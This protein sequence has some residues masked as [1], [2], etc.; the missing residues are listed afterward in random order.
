MRLIR[1][2]FVEIR[3]EFV[4]RFASRK[5]YRE[6]FGGVSVIEYVRREM[7]ENNVPFTIRSV[8][9][10]K[11]NARSA[12]IFVARKSHRI[13]SANN[14]LPDY[15]YLGRLRV[16]TAVCRQIRYDRISVF[17]GHIRPVKRNLEGN[18]SVLSVI[19]FR[20]RKIF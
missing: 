16:S 8:G 13:A 6:V 4:R 12:L 3:E 2:V 5:S 15:S 14:R 19:Y 18:R 9:N 10:G 17:H 1:I 20:K 11:G 7:R